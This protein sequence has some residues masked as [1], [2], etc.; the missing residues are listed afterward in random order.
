MFRN[1]EQFVCRAKSDLVIRAE[2]LRCERCIRLTFYSYTHRT[3]RKFVG[4]VPGM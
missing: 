1:T 3:H 2:R 4:F